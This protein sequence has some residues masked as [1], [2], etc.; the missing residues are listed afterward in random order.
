VLPTQPLAPAF[1]NVLTAVPTGFT[2][3]I[4][5]LTT[6]APDFATLYSY[7]A[8]ISISR[9]LSRELVASASYLRTGR[10]H[11]E[12]EESGRGSNAGRCGRENPYKRGL[13]RAP[14]IDM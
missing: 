12:R 13:S 14:L 5:D 3:P 11:Q 2:I 9:E 4:Q 7:N 10:A 8:N 1:P 6:V